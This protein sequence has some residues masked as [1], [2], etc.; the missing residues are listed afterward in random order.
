MSNIDCLSLLFLFQGAYRRRLAMLRV[1]QLREERMASIVI[2]STWRRNAAIDGL[3][4]SRRSCVLVQSTWRRFVAERNFFLL[5]AQR[6]D[7]A[8][9]IQRGW[10]QY[11]Q[12]C[13]LRDSSACRI[14]TSWRMLSRS[15]EYRG[16]LASAVRIQ[17]IYRGR[18]DRH[19][20]LLLQWAAL[21]IQVRSLLDIW[22][23]WY[24]SILPAHCFGSCTMNP[25]R[26]PGVAT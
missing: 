19:H 20:Y 22:H 3:D 9:L 11:C 4:Q 8:C 25:R 21:V 14:Q 2:Q 24:F 5:L 1:Q 16:V 18:L 7:A 13:Q 26:C 6:E 10:H 23:R 17:G 15:L 12:L